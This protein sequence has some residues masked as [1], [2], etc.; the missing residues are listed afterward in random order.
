M[1][2]PLIY[3]LSVRF[4][5][6]ANGREPVHEWLSGLSRADRKAIGEDIKTVQLGWPLGMPL[7]RKLEP[8]LWEVRVS[9]KDGIARILF[10]TTQ[11]QMVLLHG[12]IKKSQKLPQI[13]LDLARRRMKEIRYGHE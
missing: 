3:R 10:T 8:E 2:E 7:V 13:E 11:Q 1:S 4:Y 5:R 12:V 9:V 6:N